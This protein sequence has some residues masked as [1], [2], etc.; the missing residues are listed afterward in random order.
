MLEDLEQM[1]FGDDTE[2]RDAAKRKLFA[3]AGVGAPA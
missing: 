1:V 3:L 2:A